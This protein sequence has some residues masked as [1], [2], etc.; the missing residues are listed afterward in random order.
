VVNMG[1][2]REDAGFGICVWHLNDYISLQT[3][4]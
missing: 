1:Y 4:S 3:A 2:D